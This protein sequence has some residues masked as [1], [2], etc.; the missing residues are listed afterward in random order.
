[1]K[2][3]KKLPPGSRYHES[4]CAIFRGK[5]CD[6]DDLPPGPRRRRPPPDGDAPTPDR[7]REME[8]A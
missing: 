3:P 1:M 7:E 6:C 8:D 5:T 2:K 4:W